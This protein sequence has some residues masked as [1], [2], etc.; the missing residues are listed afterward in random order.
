MCILL[1]QYGLWEAFIVQCLYARGQKLHGLSS[2]FAF[3]MSIALPQQHN[4]SWLANEPTERSVKCAC[5]TRHSGNPAVR[6]GLSQ[7]MH[8]S[9]SQLCA[10]A[11]PVI[12]RLK[13]GPAVPFSSHNLQGVNAL[14]SCSMVQGTFCNVPSSCEGVALADGTCCPY[15]LSKSGFCCEVVDKDMECCASEVL[16]AA[17]VCQGTAVSIDYD[18]VACTVSLLGFFGAPFFGAL[19]SCDHHD[20]L[21][22]CML[23]MLWLFQEDGI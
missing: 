11:C 1:G 15:E 13:T 17:G 19:Q 4:T 3:Y 21:G 14:S 12:I 5:V 6:L 2:Q 16:D 8:G 10:C 22:R 18:G 9:Q 23:R 20:A 7:D